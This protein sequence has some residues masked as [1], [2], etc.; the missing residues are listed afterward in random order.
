MS[1]GQERRWVCPHGKTTTEDCHDCDESDLVYP[2]GWRHV[3]LAG[4]LRP[5]PPPSQTVENEWRPVP[6]GRDAA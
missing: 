5:M 4:D 2:Q 3:A 1:D 6:T